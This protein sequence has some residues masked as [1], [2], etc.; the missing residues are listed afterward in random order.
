MKWI[1]PVLILAAG[2]FGAYGLIVHKPQL[3]RQTSKSEPPL[4]TVI[5][6]EPQTVRLDVF[7]QGV[8]APR[9]EI[10]WVAEAAGKIIRLHPGFVTGGFFKRDEILAAVDS[11]DY[12]VAI[13]QTGAR[14][15]EAKRLLASEEAQAE[16]A[17][18]EWQAL[19]EG[20]PTPLALHVPQLAEA[21]AKLKAAEAD[22]AKARLQRSRCELRAPFSGRVRDKFIGL[23]QYVQVGEKLARL[24]STDAAEIRLP[25]AGDQ[26]GFLEL[27]MGMLAGQLKPK[28]AFTADFAGKRERWEGSIVRTE[29]G[30]DGATGLL[31]AVGEVREPY[32]SKHAP[33]LAGLFVQAEIEGRRQAGLFALPK[34]AVNAAQQALLVDAEGRLHI[35][36]L[37]ILRQESDRVLV[38]GGLNAGDRVVIDGIQ[39]PVEGMKVRI[40]AGDPRPEGKE[41]KDKRLETGGKE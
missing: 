25:L 36:R 19:G 38:K 8:V 5:R 33:L 11:Q 31:H 35:Q 27:P 32:S 9:T 24:Y 41:A 37:D 39:M 23:G 10:D 30:L 15:A 4:A 7:S 6:V 1:L 3:E 34:N 14:I 26:L 22:L 20:K 40:L 21:R 18:S 2:S 16:Q 28:V 13:A 17:K 12:D 29:G